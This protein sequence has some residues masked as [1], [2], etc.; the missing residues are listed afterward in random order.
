MGVECQSRLTYARRAPL[1]MRSQTERTRKS[2]QIEAGPSRLKTSGK[3]TV[4]IDGDRQDLG[5]EKGSK[6]EKEKPDFTKP[7][8]MKK[9]INRRPRVIGRR[10]WSEHGAG[11][12]RTI[13][14]P[15]R[16]AARKVVKDLL[17]IDS[18]NDIG[19]QSSCYKTP[20]CQ[21]LGTKPFLGD[22]CLA[23]RMIKPYAQ[24]SSS[25]NKNS[26]REGGP[27]KG[28]VREDG[29]SWQKPSRVSYSVLHRGHRSRE[30]AGQP[31]ETHRG[32][33]LR[34]LGSK[35]CRRKP[36]IPQRQLRILFLTHA[37]SASRT[38]QLNTDPVSPS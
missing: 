20:T 19:Q 22:Y 7:P 13:A 24:L 31:T 12:S 17:I 21:K 30:K 26:L 14:W 3:L 8:R 32:P 35:Y 5:G 15:Q 9:T 27:H 1:C 37:S 16:S 18:R 10:A 4:T 28:T 34:W 29:S 6:G 11:W 36:T 23:T 33:N 38:S 25:V 2:S